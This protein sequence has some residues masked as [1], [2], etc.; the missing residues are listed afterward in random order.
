LV[1]WLIE[2]KTINYELTFKSTIN[3][4]RF[5]VRNQYLLIYFYMKAENN[6]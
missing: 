1:E 2:D 4:N 6:Q 5:Q 3:G